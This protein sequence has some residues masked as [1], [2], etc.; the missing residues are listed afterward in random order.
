MIPFPIINKYGNVVIKPTIKTIDINSA[1]GS[2]LLQYTNGETYALGANTNSAYGTG[3]DS[4]LTTWTLLRNDVRLYTATQQYSILIT[5]DNKVYGS[6]V[7][8]SVFS[9]AFGYNIPS[10]STYQD[11]SSAFSNFDISGIKSIVGNNESANRLYVIDKNDQLWGIGNNQYY[12]LGTGSK[13]NQ[14]DWTALTN[15]TNVKSVHTTRY[16]TWIMKNDNT[17][18]RCGTNSIATAAASATGTT[19]QT[20]TAYT[21]FTVQGISCN[22]YNVIFHLSDNTIRIIGIGT[23]GQAGNGSTSTST[24][25]TP[26]NPNLTGVTAVQKSGGGLYSSIVRGSSTMLSAGA[27]TNGLLGVGVGNS[28]ISTF[29]NSSTGSIASQQLSSISTFISSTS[30]SYYIYGDE[31][32]ST[33]AAAMILS[34]TSRST[35][36]IMPTPHS[37]MA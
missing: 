10:S 3:N 30:S 31:L 25:L 13:T 7:F 14:A 6:G 37:S 18:W 16:V 2:V 35:W 28:T 5:N 33:G 29:T 34:P 23:S 15:G 1:G 24:I 22:Q 20:F 32:Y 27:N 26:Y 9:T 12:S 17:I 36:A 4:T 19:F 21:N 11:I 8:S